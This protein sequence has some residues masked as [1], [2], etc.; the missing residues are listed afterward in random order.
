MKK[1]GTKK[2]KKFAYGSGGFVRLGIYVHPDI[3]RAGVTRFSKRV[4][5][6]WEHK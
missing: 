2:W 5:S 1:C 3:Y 6:G 4:A